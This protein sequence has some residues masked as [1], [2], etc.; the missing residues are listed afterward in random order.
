MLSLIIHELATNAVKHGALSAPGGRVTIEWQADR[1]GNEGYVFRLCWSE[2]DGPP[3]AV[4]KWRGYGRELLETAPHLSLKAKVCSA[5][6]PKGWSIF[7]R[8]R[9]PGLERCSDRSDCGFAV[10]KHESTGVLPNYA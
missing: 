1:G 7:W 5:L 6:S 2:S 3:V 9:F 10:H 8:R 4:P